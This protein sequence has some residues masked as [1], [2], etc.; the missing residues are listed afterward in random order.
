MRNAPVI[1]TSPKTAKLPPTVNNAYGSGDVGIFD[2]T[3]FIFVAIYICGNP[4]IGF[5]LII[6][7][8]IPLIDVFDSGFVLFPI[9]KILLL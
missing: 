9:A 2:V 4:P 1:F 5:C 7:G 6:N 8:R 3:P